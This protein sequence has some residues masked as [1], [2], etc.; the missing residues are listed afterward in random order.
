MQPQ[1]INLKINNKLVKK[2]HRMIVCLCGY[3]EVYRWS[4]LFFFFYSEASYRSREGLIIWK[5]GLRYPPKRK[6]PLIDIIPPFLK[7]KLEVFFK[8]R[9]S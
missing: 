9:I 3:A 1:H 7:R 8:S 2:N 5:D 4:D 6:Y